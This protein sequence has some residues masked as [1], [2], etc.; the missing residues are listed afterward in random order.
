MADKLSCMLSHHAGKKKNPTRIINPPLFVKTNLGRPH[1]KP[2]F[3][4]IAA[5]VDGEPCCDWVGGTGSGHYVKMVHNGIEYGD[6]Q[7][8][9]EAYH[10][11]KEALGVSADELSDIFTEWN[12]GE[13]DSYLIEITRDILKF[14]DTDGS[15]LIDHIKD[16]AGQVSTPKKFIFVIFLNQSGRGRWH[17]FVASNGGSHE[18][19]A[20][21]SDRTYLSFVMDPPCFV[22]IWYKCHAH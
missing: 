13:L 1:L 19:G 15:P 2:I 10:V 12:Q 9:C 17:P 18:G 16:T 21:P 4:S 6:M 14:K 5:Q 3:Q 8:I 20:R 7:M 22:I 11:M